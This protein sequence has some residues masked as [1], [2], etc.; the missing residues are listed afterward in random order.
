MSPSP[1]QTSEREAFRLEA[2]VGLVLRAGVMLSSA[3][4][5]LGLVLSLSGAA[6]PAAGLLLQI[7]IL[8]LLATPVARVIISI[9]E[10][11][12]E[13]D[14][15]FTTLTLIVLVELLASVV[16]ALFFERKL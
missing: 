16:A 1:H 9:T 7:G 12:R 3:C 2:T 13:R 4:L 15:R 5:A 14:W 8:T 11:V 10:Y 6:A